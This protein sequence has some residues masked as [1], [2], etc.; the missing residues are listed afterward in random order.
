MG[1]RESQGNGRR[2]LTTVPDLSCRGT[3]LLTTVCAVSALQLVFGASTNA[4]QTDS[5]CA[6]LYLSLV[7]SSEVF[8]NKLCIF[9]LLLINAMCK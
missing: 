8:I 6:K 4:E 1:H 7:R 2:Q 3:K 5:I 9:N